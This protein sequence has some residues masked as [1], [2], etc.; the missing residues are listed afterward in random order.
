MPTR[1]EP[2]T[3]VAISSKTPEIEWIWWS[4]Y[5][6]NAIGDEHFNQRLKIAV[7]SLVVRSP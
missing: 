6:H 7:E 5:K 4:L 1:K 3:V 2:E